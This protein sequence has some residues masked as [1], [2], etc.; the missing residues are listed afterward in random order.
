MRR[1]W[2]FVASLLAVS[3]VALWQPVAGAAAV[4]CSLGRPVPQL[5]TCAE[6]VA[7]YND[8]VNW[9]I[10]GFGALDL[11]A[12]PR[13]LHL[14]NP[15]LA[16]FWRFEAATGI[17]R[18]EYEFGIINYSKDQYFETAPTAAH[19]SA[20]VI[21]P[22]GIVTAHTAHVMSRLL[23]AEQQEV[24]NLVAMDTA[25]NRATYAL[26]VN[27]HDWAN[28]QAYLAAGF[29][30][31]AA[32]A[33]GSV[34]GRQHKV[35]KALLHAGLRFGVGPA[36]QKAMQRYVR[37][38]RAFP[39]A[40]QQNM[41]TLGMTPTTLAFAEAAFVKAKPNPITYS[42]TQY[43]SSAKVIRAERK[44]ASSLRGFASQTPTAPRPS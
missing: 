2:G 4:N 39:K 11:F 23:S 24:V 7:L 36:D 35:T 21:K 37:K 22:S 15:A 1:S 29:A 33:I 40:V 43:L 5:A 9:A 38:H 18:Y 27:R 10:G 44:A 20:P 8:S 6:K 26:T 19:L 17:T 32:S 14:N 41:L 34:I 30:R 42:M 3:G 31:H 12:A 28:Y 13:P 16:S 25:L